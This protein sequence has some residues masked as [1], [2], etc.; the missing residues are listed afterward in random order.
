ME[1]KLSSR[2][3]PVIP[4]KTELTNVLFECPTVWWRTPHLLKLNACVAV[5]LLSA[6]T[7]GFDG[8]MMNGLQSL[9]TW[10]SY[11]GNPSGTWLGLMNAVMPLG[12]VRT[13][14]ESPYWAETLT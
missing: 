8:S 13:H 1:S 14:R 9:D 5:V 7:M 6:T 11:F 3:E 2:S 12:V 4:E 10:N